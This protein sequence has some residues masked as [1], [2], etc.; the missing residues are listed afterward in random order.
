MRLLPKES[1]CLLSVYSQVVAN[2]NYYKVLSQKSNKRSDLSSKLICKDYIFPLNYTDIHSGKD[3][4][5]NEGRC[6]L[7][8]VIASRILI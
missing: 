2:L 8:D 6:A 3:Q 1:K 4:Q 5:Y 7:K